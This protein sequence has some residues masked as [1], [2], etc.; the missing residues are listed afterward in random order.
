M[1]VGLPLIEE[2]RFIGA[3]KTGHSQLTLRVMG[4]HPASKNNHRRIQSL[5]FDA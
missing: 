2:F 3:A 1:P 4:Q 5:A